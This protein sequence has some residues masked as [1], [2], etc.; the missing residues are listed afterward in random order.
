[1]KID[2]GY[3]IDSWGCNPAG[4]VPLFKADSQPTVFSDRLAQVAREDGTLYFTQTNPLISSCR[5]PSNTFLT[6]V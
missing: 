2:P 5:S 1:M 4:E 6:V 3:H